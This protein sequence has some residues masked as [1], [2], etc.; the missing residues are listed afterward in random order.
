M[1]VS[2]SALTAILFFLANAS[3]LASEQIFRCIQAD[4]SP[5]FQ[6]TQCVGQGESVVVGSVQGGWTSLRSGEKALLKTYRDRNAKH[7]RRS[8]KVAKK[9]K[10]IETAACWNKRKRL[11]AVSAKLRRGYKSSQ[12]EGLRRKRDN[13]EEYL[14]KYCP[15]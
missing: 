8:R 13:Y 3:T 10:S 9:T 4:G 5:S 2:Q 12:G 14:H 11:N 6:K 7:K 1:S 15:K